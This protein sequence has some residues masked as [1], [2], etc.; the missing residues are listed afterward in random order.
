VRARSGPEDGELLGVSG[1]EQKLHHG[2]AE[3]ISQEY[4]SFTVGPVDYRSLATG[5]DST[6]QVVSYGL[7]LLHHRSHPLALLQRAASVEHGRPQ[8]SVEVVSAA[9]DAVSTPSSPTCGS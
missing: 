9:P 6:R 8:A 5:P 2:L 1:G 3:L 7:R 4:G